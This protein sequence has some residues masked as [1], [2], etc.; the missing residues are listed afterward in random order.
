ML[1]VNSGNVGETGQK[2]KDLPVGV[3]PGGDW[4]LL[5]AVEPP[6]FRAVGEE[7]EP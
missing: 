5:G 2:Q 4:G 7:T 1:D 3:W 6:M